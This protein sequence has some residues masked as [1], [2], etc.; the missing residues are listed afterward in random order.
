[1]SSP[2]EVVAGDG[3]YPVRSLGPGREFNVLS[4]GVSGP[5]NAYELVPCFTS[6]RGVAWG[7]LGPPL[8]C[9]GNL[10]AVGV[11]LVPGVPGRPPLAVKKPGRFS[12]I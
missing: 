11:L 7:V 5:L 12:L 1:M 10:T 8:R 9:L 2:R 3:S 4:H 6:L